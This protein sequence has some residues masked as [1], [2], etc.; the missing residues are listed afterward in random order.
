MKKIQL[1]RFMLLAMLPAL[2]LTSCRFED[3]DYFGESA[4]LRIEHESQELQNLL[5]SAPNGWVMQYFCG[6][7]VAQFE[8]FNLFARFEDSNKVTLAGNHRFL[9]DGNQNKYTEATSVYE[10]LKEDGLVLAFNVWNDVLTP[11]VDPVSYGYAPRNIVKDG[12]GMEG[13]HNFVVVSSNEDE[14]IL[15]GERHSAEVRLVKC[16][17]SWED[18]IADT[19]ELKNSITNTSINDYYVVNADNDTLYFQGL[20]NGRFLYTDNLDKTKSVKVDSLACVFTPNGFRTEREDSIEAYKFHE[21][22]LAEDKTCLTNED[23]NVKVIARWDAYIAN[24]TAVWKMD[25]SLFTAEQTSLFNQIDAELKKNNANWSLESIGIGKSTGSG[26]VIGLVLTFYTNTAKTRTNT[27]GL[28]LTMNRPEYGQIAINCTTED[29]IDK[30]METIL[31][32]ATDIESL[33]RSFAALLNGTYQMTPDDYFLPTS[34][35]FEAI[36]G[37]TTFKL[38]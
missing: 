37:G 25:P 31:K 28:A 34:V 18:Y 19:D 30:N 15:R 13:D 9:R 24:H 8:G 14:V 12:V 22:T 5:V 2:V 6:T 23:G 11:F 29:K 26:S 21:F 7:G 16:D 35:Q 33:C 4:A 32:K 36:S 3:D 10:M 38:N 20:R 17:R 1:Y 27:A